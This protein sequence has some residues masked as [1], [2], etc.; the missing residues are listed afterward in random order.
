MRTEP[1]VIKVKVRKSPTTTP[2]QQ[3]SGPPLASPR[4]SGGRVSSEV[5]GAASVST[6]V[7]SATSACSSS[8]CIFCSE[9]ASEGVDTMN[10]SFKTASKMGVLECAELAVSGVAQARHDIAQ[11]VQALVER[12]D[13]DIDIRMS[14]H[15]V[16]QAERRGD[17]ADVRETRNA[18]PLENVDGVD[19][20]ATG[21]QHGI[22]G[23]TH[24]EVDLVRQAVIVLQR[25]QGPFIAPQSQVPDLR[26]GDHLAKALRQAKSGAQNRRDADATG[27]LVA[28]H[29]CQWRLRLAGLQG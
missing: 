25:L 1:S 19:R 2:R 8:G 4:A 29:G 14:L 3:P 6:G 16:L 7:S 26:V 17:N 12:R 15:Q 21:C 11:I 20:G 5:G 23:V 28:L 9:N 22:D 13:I 18:A 24:L 10:Q 27:Q